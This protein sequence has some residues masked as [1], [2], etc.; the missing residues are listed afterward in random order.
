[1]KVN[2][3]KTVLVQNLFYSTVIC[4]VFSKQDKSS[5]FDDRLWHPLLT[6]EVGGRVPLVARGPVDERPSI[7]S[8]WGEQLV[9]L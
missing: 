1:M 9:A 8:N 6:R 4:L 2:E 7:H 3:S 5:N